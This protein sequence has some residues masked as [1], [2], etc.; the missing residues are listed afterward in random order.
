MKARG[1]SLIELIVFIAIISI[2]AIGSMVAFKNILNQSSETGQNLQASQ[3]AAARM[4]III[5]Y[6]LINGFSA[7]TDPC[8]VGSL[9]ACSALN[10]F[11]TQN[12]FTHIPTPI[13]SETGFKTA[14]ITITGSGNATTSVRFAE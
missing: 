4:N 13:L 5:M 11:A 12:G 3:L 1:F 2:I 9:A 7:I 6:R 10:N 8:E 14:T